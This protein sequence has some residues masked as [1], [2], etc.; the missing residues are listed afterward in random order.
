MKGTDDAT[1]ANNNADAN[2]P[3]DVADAWLTDDVRQVATAVVALRDED[4]A[5]LF[6]RDLCTVTEL[7]E[8]GERWHVARMLDA[9]RSY[10]EIQRETGASSATI[11]RVGQWLRYGRG[12]YR[13]V[14]DRLAQR[15]AGRR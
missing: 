10:A 12:G 1:A 9:G 4:E 11:S 15:E 13:L 14:I 3:T 7:R 6:L 8:F 5:L 2:T